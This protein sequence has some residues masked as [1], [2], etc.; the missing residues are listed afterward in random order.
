MNK[1][2]RVSEGRNLS[3]PWKSVEI[4]SSPVLLCEIAG[5]ENGDFMSVKAK[6]VSMSTSECV[7]SSTMEKEL[8]KCE[9]VISD[10]TAAICLC[11]WE[12][13]V[14]KVEKGRSYLC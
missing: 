6:V 8:R 2:S 5:G 11:L 4:S 10:G 14:E 12:D 7:Y 1:Y 9:V 13:M 3:F